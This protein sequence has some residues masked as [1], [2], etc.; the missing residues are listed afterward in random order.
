MSSHRNFFAKGRRR[1]IA[2][3]ILLCLVLILVPSL[4]RVVA[5]FVLQ[6]FLAV[7]SWVRESPDL[8]PVYLRERSRLL[9]D[10]AALEARLDG[11]VATELTIARLVEEN[12]AL[13]AFHGDSALPR[14]LARVVARPPFLPY[15]LLQ[16]DVGEVDG[17]SVG[18]PVFVGSD[19][20]I[21]S[22][23]SVSRY[24]AFV[25][26]VSA[27][28]FRTT[29]YLPA[30]Q[31]AAPMEGVGGGVSRI[32][33]PQ[34]VQ[35]AAHDLVITMAEEPGVYGSVA[36]VES[37]PTQPEQYAYVRLPEAL[38]SIR[39]VTIG[40]VPVAPRQPEVLASSTIAFVEKYFYRPDV[41]SLLTPSSTPTSST[42][43]ATTAPSL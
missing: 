29:V 13:R 11:L 23:V 31:L 2:A 1:L 20:V 35:V 28:G 34:G 42:P 36:Y 18:A 5:G 7:A 40:A 15:D 32:R 6:P 38:Q 22:V 17:V 14:Q 21:G 19:I 4:A 37:S 33:F 39:F 30:A 25:Q 9:D 3:G 26:L 43:T 12:I 27:P 16:I 41:I 10:Q 24:D 8:F